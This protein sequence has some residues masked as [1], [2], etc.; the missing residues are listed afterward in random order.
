M[1]VCA[2]V[3]TYVWLQQLMNAIAM[4]H[5]IQRL[6]LNSSTSLEVE[7][8]KCLTIDEEVDGEAQAEAEEGTPNKHIPLYME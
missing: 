1:C 2:Y 3:Y 8:H 4:V 5:K 7:G 6:A